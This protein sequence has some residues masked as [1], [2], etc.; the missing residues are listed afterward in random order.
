MLET[1]AIFGNVQPHLQPHLPQP[2]FGA[3]QSWKA[4]VRQL[5]LAAGVGGRRDLISWD[6]ELEIG[7]TTIVSLGHSSLEAVES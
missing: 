4:D 3:G 6:D 2:I 5:L 7:T 1:L